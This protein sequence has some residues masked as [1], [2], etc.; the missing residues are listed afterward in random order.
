MANIKF[1]I[2]CSPSQMFSDFCVGITEDRRVTTTT[3]EWSLLG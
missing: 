3:V 1:S 2:Y